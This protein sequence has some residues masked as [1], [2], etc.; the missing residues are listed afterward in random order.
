MSLTGTML[1][2]LLEITREGK[3]RENGITM[4]TDDLGS[5]DG[6]LLA[7]SADCIDY[8]KIGLGL[9]LMLERSWLLERVRRFHDLGIKVMSG[10]TLMEV[11]AQRGVVSQVLEG[12]KALEFDLVEVSDFAGGVT[13]ETK[14]TI[15]SK[16]TQLSMDYIF[17]V[18]SRDGL[19]V[20]PG[21]T[22]TKIQEAL[23]LKSQKVVVEVPR[24][25][26]AAGRVGYQREG[27]EVLDE[28]AGTFGPPKIIF[29]SQQMQQLT[30]LILE[31][32]PTVNLAGLS[33]N[34]ALVLEMQRLGL[35]FETLG[36]SRPLQSVEGSPASKFIYHLIRAEHPVDQATLCLRSGL[37][38]RTVQAALS[39][40]VDGGLVRQV[41]DASDMRKH[42]YTIR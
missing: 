18:G 29:E 3:P 42:R 39:A 32:G 4:A 33:L 41:P 6:G 12:L 2:E 22:I 38:R 37:P 8:V 10:G 24:E 21:Q 40:L 35:T 20:S 16:A 1:E 15:A 5:L 19:P 30:A 28:V 26:L 34:D 7:E 11:A 23:D 36:L 25:G 13:L 31:F 9:P 17:E 14:R 27:W